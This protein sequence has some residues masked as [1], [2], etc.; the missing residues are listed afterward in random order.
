MTGELDAHHV[1]GLAL[2]PVGR[3]PD[4][5]DS[6]HVLTIGDF[7]AHAKV[8]VVA[9]AVDFIHDLEAGLLAHVIK[10]GEVHEVV[11]AQ[12]I[13]AI[14]QQ[15]LRGGEADVER[16]LATKLGGAEHGFSKFFLQSGDH[17]RGVHGRSQ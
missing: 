15:R 14:L 8:L 2:V 5:A 7:G 17:L 6:R 4:I 12:L 13:A 11:K 3:G 1:P 9:V 16:L 10:R